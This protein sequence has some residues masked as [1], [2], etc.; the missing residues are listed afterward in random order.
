MP[1]D[2]ILVGGEK[3]GTG[4]TTIATNLA[5]LCAAA[6]EDVCLVDTDPQGSASYWV[7]LRAEADVP[8]LASVRLHGQGVVAQLRDL[9]GRYGR[10]I[11]DAGGRD[12]VELRAAMTVAPRLMVPIQASQFDT[13]T[14]EAMSKL[15][16]QAGGF[17]PDLRTQLVINR[18]SPNP[19]V[20]EADDVRELVAEYPAFAAMPLLIRDR[21]AYRR[22]A[23]EGLAVTEDGGDPKAADEITRVHSEVTQA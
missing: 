11:V 2:M 1:H 10:V 18:A 20:S 22:A 9:A 12:S 7:A 14:L 6:G 5:A 23:R 16:E 21:I 4:K 19:R 15:V 13:W 8:Q 3:G 17:N